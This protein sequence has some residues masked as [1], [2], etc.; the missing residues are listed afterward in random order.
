MCNGFTH[1]RTYDDG[2]FK[3]S[4]TIRTHLCAVLVTIRCTN[5]IG[6]FRSTNIIRTYRSPLVVS[7][8]H[9]IHH[10]HHNTSHDFDNRCHNFIYSRHYYN[11]GSP[12]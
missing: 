10:N 5:I 12:A 7:D 8:Y 1:G 4:N 3:V 6:A 11:I 2:A 9:H